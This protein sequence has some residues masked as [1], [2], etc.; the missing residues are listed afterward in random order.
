MSSNF[1]SHFIASRTRLVDVR[2][3]ENI[4]QAK[5]GIQILYLVHFNKVTARAKGIDKKSLLIIVRI[6]IH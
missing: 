3:L 2:D 5:G 1:K 6:V 4:K